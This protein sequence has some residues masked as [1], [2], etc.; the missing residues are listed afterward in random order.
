MRLYNTYCLKAGST[1]AKV[2]PGTDVKFC[3]ARKI[4]GAFSNPHPKHL[5]L[6]YALGIKEFK[7]MKTYLWHSIN[8]MCPFETQTFSYSIYHSLSPSWVALGRLCDQPCVW[9]GTH[10]E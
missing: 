5:L 6:V 3:E 8:P 7:N 9:G 1:L 10:S 4:T 2:K